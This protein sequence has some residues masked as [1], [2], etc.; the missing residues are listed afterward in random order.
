[1][2]CGGYKTQKRRGGREKV[3]EKMGMTALA[4]GRG[5]PSA[6]R[7]VGA[8][9]SCT[10]RTQHSVFVFDPLTPMVLQ[11]LPVTSQEKG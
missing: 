2:Q 8:D 11:D 10:P 3:E 1:M 6:G 9:S 5:G 4:R 7:R